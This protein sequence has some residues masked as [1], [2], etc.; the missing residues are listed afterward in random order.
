MNSGFVIWAA[1]VVVAILLVALFVAIWF[2][3]RPGTEET[4]LVAERPPPAVSLSS[5]LAKTRDA[6]AGRLGGLLGGPL[7]DAFWQGLEE[8]L[9]AADV[10]PA[11]SAR[12]VEQ[13]KAAK[14]EDGASARVSLRDQMVAGFEGPDRSIHLTTDPSVILV[15]GVNGTGKTTSIAKLARRLQQEGKRVVIGAADTFRAGAIDQLKK[16][17]DRTGADFVGAEPGADPASVAF[18]ALEQAKAT[19]ADVVIVDTAGRLHNNKNLMEEL[20]KVVRVL[21]REAGGIDNVMLVIDATTGQNGIVQAEAF[22]AVAPVNGIIL[23]KMDG[24]AKGGVIAAIEHETGI[25]VRF[26]GVGEAMDDLIPF[27]PPAFV[28]AL[29]A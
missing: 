16:W 20:A 24:T 3:R 22:V 12:I 13:V 17:A 8:T 27:E 14:P 1:V 23:T 15:V 10:G 26:I 19:E 6:I 7:D 25:P 21:D 5:R 11:T 4:T 2:Q 29:L 18:R 28:D 9:I